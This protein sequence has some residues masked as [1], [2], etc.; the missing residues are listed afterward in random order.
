[1]ESPEIK[2]FE[3][4]TASL[5][6]YANNAKEHSQLQVEQIANSIEEFGF[7]DPIAVWENA[8]GEMEVVEGHG[9]V[10]AAQ[11]LGMGKVPVFYLNHLSDEQRRAYTHVHNQTTLNSGF[12]PLKLDMDIKQLDFDWESFGFEAPEPVGDVLTDT[13]EQRRSLAERFGIAPFSVLNARE[14]AWQERKRQWLALG[15]KSELG[16]GG[17]L[18]FQAG[19]MGKSRQYRAAASCR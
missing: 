3:V 14:G 17:G 13:D 1:M 6:P 2:V 15:I 11:R 18:A 16:R 12:D 19:L 10:L 4:P 8:D 7:N 5:V 9:R